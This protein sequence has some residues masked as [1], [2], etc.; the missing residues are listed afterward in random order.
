MNDNA[1]HATVGLKFEKCKMFSKSHGIVYNSF[2]GCG[3]VSL[4]VVVRYLH[5]LI[6]NNIPFMKKNDTNTLTDPRE[7]YYNEDF[8]SQSQP[9]PGVEEKMSPRPDTGEQSYRRR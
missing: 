5:F 9:A 8:P 3:D 2:S 6:R 1:W 7:A 4:H